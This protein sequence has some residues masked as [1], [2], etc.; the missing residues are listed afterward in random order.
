MLSQAAAAL[1]SRL[2]TRPAILKPEI[3]NVY[4]QFKQ[5]LPAI[6]Q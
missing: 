4:M 5:K 1:K 6:F 2:Q 3:S